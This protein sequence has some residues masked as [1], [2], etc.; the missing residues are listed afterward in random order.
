MASRSKKLR[1]LNALYARIPNANCKGLCANQCS[2]I[3]LLQIEL[4][5]LEAALGRK[6][7]LLASNLPSTHAMAHIIAPNLTDQKCPMLVDKRCSVYE[8][9]PLICRLYGVVELMICPH[10]CQP[11]RILE[12]QEARAI[13]REIEQI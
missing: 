4:D 8:Q 5:N 2:T 13:Q 3:P 7:V 1:V 6:L 11:E 12:E 9:R 10:G